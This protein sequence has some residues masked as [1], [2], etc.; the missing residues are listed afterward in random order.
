M[1]GAIIAGVIAA[2][3]SIVSSQQN[4]KQ[5]NSAQRWAANQSAT[6]HQ[7]EISDLRAAGLNPMLSGT[8]G[9]GASTTPGIPASI[10]DA[11]GAGLSSAQSARRMHEELA[12]LRE[13]N[14]L[15]KAQREK[16]IQETDASETGE[17]NTALQNRLLKLS[18]PK[19]ENAAKAEVEVG[20][21]VRNVER[22]LETIGIGTKSVPNLKH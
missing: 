19:A 9:S 4:I 8:G 14:S 3:G 11:L 20:S 16:T 15:I 17:I 2:I 10:P 7:R 5:A 22:I 12:N 18:M 1:W 6:A 13:T 21:K